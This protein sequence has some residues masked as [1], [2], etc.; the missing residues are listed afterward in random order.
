M[1]IAA[2]T[3]AFETGIELIDT[4]HR[5]LFD[6]VNRL[7]AAF[8]GGTSADEAR[9]CLD[10]LLGYTREH[11]ATEEQFMRDLSY[12]AL[13]LHGAQHAE[14]MRQTQALKARADAGQPVALDIAVLMADWLRHHIN[15]EDMGYVE[16]LKARQRP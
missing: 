6:A 1:T 15:D 14:L 13:A 10:F 8:Q 4:Q 9:A 11:F 3:S 2:W 12:P 7:A 16:Y 5:T